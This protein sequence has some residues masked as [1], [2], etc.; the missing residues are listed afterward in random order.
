MSIQDLTQ[1][2]EDSVVDRLAAVEGVADVTLNGDREPL[3][4]VLIDPN[5]L[6]ARGLT[7]ADLETA[8]ETVALDAPAGSLSGNN[9]SL[10]VRADASVTSGEEVEAIRINR[11]T[12]V[13]DVADV[14]FGPAETD[15]LAPHQRPDR[16][17]PRHRPPGA[18]EHARHLR[19]ACAPPSPSSNDALPEGVSHPRHLRRRDLHR[20]RAGEGAAH[21]R[22]GDADRRRA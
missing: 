1:L 2:V 16:H 5:A 12:R 22:R 6:A 11:A 20:R 14:I 18:V 7:V 8:L 17:R 15:E 3:V 4:R 9:Q 10:L 21:A 13:G 19:R